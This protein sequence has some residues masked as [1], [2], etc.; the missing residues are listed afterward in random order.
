MFN[1]GVTSDGIKEY[2]CKE[3]N[4]LFFYRIV[5][6]KDYNNNNNELLKSVYLYFKNIIEKNYKNMKK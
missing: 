4:K 6:H 5:L 2:I 1:K 3:I